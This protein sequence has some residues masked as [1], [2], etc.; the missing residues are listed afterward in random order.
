MT[1]TTVSRP[2]ATATNLGP[3]ANAL[4]MGP[5]G[6]DV[7]LAL[8]GPSIPAAQHPTILQIAQ[9]LDTIFMQ[10]GFV[11]QVKTPTTLEQSSLAR[12]ARYL[13][14]IDPGFYA[15]VAATVA[16][17]LGLCCDRAMQSELATLTAADIR[18]TIWRQRIGTSD[19]EKCILI[20]GRYA[21]MADTMTARSYYRRA[22]NT[23]VEHMYKHARMAHLHDDRRLAVAFGKKAMF[24]FGYIGDIEQMTAIDKV[25]RPL[26]R[27]SDFI[28]AYRPESA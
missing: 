16:L 14:F 28:L 22:A 7:A 25:I 10:Q 1:V 6:F 18:W 3:H 4:L 19:V 8:Y 23:Q 9:L 12:F 20:G 13:H 2:L 17:S 26:W 21:L 15:D 24:L 5:A 11:L 27:S